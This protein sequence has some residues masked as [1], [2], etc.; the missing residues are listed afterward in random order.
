MDALRRG[1]DL[2]RVHLT[3]TGRRNNGLS[4]LRGLDGA[5]NR[6]G[7]GLYIEAQLEPTLK[8]GDNIMLENL[9]ALQREKTKR[10]LHGVFPVP[11]AQ[12]PN[13]NPSILRQA[14]Y[15]GFSKLKARLRKTRV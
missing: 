4:P 13:L 5:M 9:P 14:Q 1:Y 10:A 8:Q 11:P 7:L 15:G 3:D 12:S 6:E 2:L